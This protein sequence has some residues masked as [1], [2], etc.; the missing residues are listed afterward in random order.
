MDEGEQPNTDDVVAP[1]ETTGLLNEEVTLQAKEDE[2]QP[3]TDDVVAPAEIPPSV[4]NNNP[5]SIH[6][7]VSELLTTC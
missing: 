3:N 7:N 1:V 2:L 5:V 4:N 6:L